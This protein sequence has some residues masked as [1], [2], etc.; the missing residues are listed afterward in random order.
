MTAVWTLLHLSSCAQYSFALSIY[1]FTSLFSCTRAGSH[2]HEITSKITYRS[3]ADRLIS[4]RFSLVLVSK[5]HGAYSYCSWSLL[6]NSFSSPPCFAPQILMKPLPLASHDSHCHEFIDFRNC[7]IL[8][9]NFNQIPSISMR[10]ACASLSFLE[11]YH[12]D[13]WWKITIAKVLDCCFSWLFMSKMDFSMGNI[14]V[15]LKNSEFL[16]M[17][18]HNLFPIA[19]IFSDFIT[20]TKNSF[21]TFP[22]SI[23]WVFLWFLTFFPV[24]FP[25]VLIPP[26][27]QNSPIV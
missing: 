10:K 14:F 21:W 15:V 24:N 4:T 9:D 25:T 19:M 27:C 12:R 22:K 13:L 18:H 20:R 3:S 11:G 8:E 17:N 1:P 2:A 23:I 7:K 16:S 5:N 26:H 6:R